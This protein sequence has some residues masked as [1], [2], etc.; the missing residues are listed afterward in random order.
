MISNIKKF[1]KDFFWSF[2][3]RLCGFLGIF[4]LMSLSARHLNN[5]DFANFVLIM[6]IIPGLVTIFTFGQDI[7]SSKLL[8]KSKNIYNHKKF[9]K[10]TFV[11]SSIIFFFIYNVLVFSKILDNSLLTQSIVSIIFLSSI[12]RI[13]ADYS[14]AT[15]NFRNF[16]FFNSL[17]SNGGISMWVIFFCLLA[18]QFF[19]YGTL[20][21]ELIFLFISIS[22]L[23]SIIIFF[24][25]KKPKIIDFYITLKDVLNIDKEYKFFLKISFS[26]MISTLLVMLRFDHDILLVNFFSSKNDVSLYASIIKISALIMIPL[27]IFESMI[28]HKFALLYQDGD[29][30]ELEKFVRRISTYMFYSSLILIVFIFLFSE[31]ILNIIFG[32]NFSQAHLGLKILSLSF[33]AN[34]SLGPCAPILLIIKYE[35]INVLINLFFLLFS[36]ILGSILISHFGYLGMVFTFSITMT[37]VH[38][39]FYVITKKL[40][41]INTLPYIDLRKVF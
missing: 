21:L 22:C 31:D 20:S 15:D 6:S 16:I 34:I 28:P 40:I 30:K 7:I 2:L 8:P 24:L 27:S 4:V 18:C 36:L 38:L 13:V 10:K 23:V 26:L 9:V 17:R 1:D 33:I 41:K 19:F 25:V 14:R 39:T 3:G 35:R 29:N 32:E 37:L 11:L 5:V 12:L